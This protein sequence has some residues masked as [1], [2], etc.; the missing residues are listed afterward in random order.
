MSTTP[1]GWGLDV[2]EGL[3]ISPQVDHAPQDHADPNAMGSGD[4]HHV[5]LDLGRPS[6]QVHEH[7]RLRPEAGGGWEAVAVA[8]TRKLQALA[9]L[10]LTWVRVER[11]ER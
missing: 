1:N 8:L 2:D 6:L 4:P 7:F 9:Q 10:G 3:V 11:D 5:S